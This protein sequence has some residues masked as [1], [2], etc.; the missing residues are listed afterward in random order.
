MVRDDRRIGFTQ[1]LPQTHN[2]RFAKP[3]C[4]RRHWPPGQIAQPVQPRAM[5]GSGRRRIKLQRGDRKLPGIATSAAIITRK[6]PRHRRIAAKCM[7]HGQIGSGA[8]L[9]YQRSFVGKQLE[10]T[11]HIED[12]AIR[13]VQRHQRGEPAKLRRHV[14]QE[15]GIAMRI[16]RSHRQVG[17]TGLSIRQRQPRLQ[18]KL[19]GAGV[20][21]R[22]PQRSLD[23][24]D[25]NQ[26]L[27]RLAELLPIAP[28]DPFAGQ[29]GEPQRQTAPFP[30]RLHDV[31]PTA[32]A[33]A[34]PPDR[35]VGAR[36]LP[37]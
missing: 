29:I 9:S 18:A 19:Q 37:R 21:R 34:H 2:R 32:I 17:E 8:Q 3:R 31:Y 20:H 7:A 1:Y 5:Q 25:K 22:Q 11:G 15:L 26:W 14:P 10:A 12:Q 35:H 16:M 4:D 30:G 23:L 27:K 6:C 24:F 36:V 13:S 28:L 33:S